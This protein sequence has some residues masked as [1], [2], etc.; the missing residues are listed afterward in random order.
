LSIW[1]TYGTLNPVY[2]TVLHC[3]ASSHYW[4]DIQW[5]TCCLFWPTPRSSSTKIRNVH[6][7]VNTKISHAKKS[8]RL[9][10]IAFHCF[11]QFHLINFITSGRFTAYYVRT[12]SNMLL[13]HAL[14]SLYMIYAHFTMLSVFNH[15]FAIHEMVHVSVLLHKAMTRLWLLMH[16]L[17]NV[18]IIMITKYVHSTWS[19]LVPADLGHSLTLHF[20][21]GH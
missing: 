11:K 4:T 3:I 15:F 20:F 19:V 8:Y 1:L 10:S 9:R 7:K 13:V 16:L 14:C 18:T 17:V 6:W 5:F 12:N 21:T 2:C